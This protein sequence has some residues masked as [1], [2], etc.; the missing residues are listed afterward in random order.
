MK[1]R[2]PKRKWGPII[3]LIL[4]LVGLSVGSLFYG[5]APSSEKVKYNGITFTASGQIWTAKI[6]GAEAAFSFL[7]TD[8]EN[9]EIKNDFSAVLSGKYEID[10]T[11]EVNST[12]K[13]AIALAEHQM[14][15]TLGAY[16]I[17]LRNGFIANN[18]FNF[19]IITC[20]NASQYT[21]VIYFRYSNSTSI[22]VQNNCVIAEAPSSTEF[23]RV[24]DR[25]LYGILGVMK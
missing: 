18:S 4:I 11:S 14:G 3:F 16:N 2:T 12:G 8:V 7:P 9:I 25:L 19:P 23:I 5:F 6:N 20:S 22:S 15:L 21:P 24:K 10:A 17:F 13:E 1:E